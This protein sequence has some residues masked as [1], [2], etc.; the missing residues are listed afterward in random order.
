MKLEETS[1]KNIKVLT[2]LSRGKKNQPAIALPNTV[3]NPY[4]QQGSHPDVVER[5]WDK[6]GSSL[7]I[8]CRCLVFG[9][10][11]LVHPTA[12]IIF[13]VSIGT[14]YC[15]RLNSKLMSD[16]QKVGVKTQI[17]WAGGKVMDTQRDLGPDW[18]LGGWFVDEMQWCNIVYEELGIS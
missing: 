4:Y 6:I 18:I 11:A 2:Y 14:V 10:P 12:G 5:V 9:S 1:E 7:P 16:A 15:L 8:D 17:K 3:K 13:A